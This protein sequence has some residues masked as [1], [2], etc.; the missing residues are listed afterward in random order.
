MLMGAIRQ[1]I[2]GPRLL[3]RAKDDVLP[4]DLTRELALIT[5][6]PQIGT[7]S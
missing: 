7:N 2:P 1:S 4:G 3:E 6:E 5:R